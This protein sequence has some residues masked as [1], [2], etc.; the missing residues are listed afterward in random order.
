MPHYR[1]SKL[2]MPVRS[3]SPAPPIG[4]LGAMNRPQTPAFEM[5]SVPRSCHE[6]PSGQVAALACRVAMTLFV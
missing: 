2:V 4:L 5:A 3:R 6:G 1:S